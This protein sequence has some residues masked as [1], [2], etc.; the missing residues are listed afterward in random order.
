MKR[1]RT[2]CTDQNDGSL[3]TMERVAKLSNQVKDGARKTFKCVQ[4]EG[5]QMVTIIVLEEEAN[6]KVEK[7]LGK[8]MGLPGVDEKRG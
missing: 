7:A 4:L 2:E 1:A 8:K 3:G 5:G 6:D